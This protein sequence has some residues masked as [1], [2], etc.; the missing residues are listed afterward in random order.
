MEAQPARQLEKSVTCRNCGDLQTVPYSLNSE[1]MRFESLVECK[2]CHKYFPVTPEPITFQAFC[3]YCEKTVTTIPI[4]DRD[5]LKS[6]LD[7]DREIH[8]M[9]P[10]ETGDHEW[11]LN[12]YEKENLRNVIAKGLL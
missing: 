9:H 12:N 3:P 7:R 2:N 4:L 8:V 6:A 5:E 10:A 11:R 1:H